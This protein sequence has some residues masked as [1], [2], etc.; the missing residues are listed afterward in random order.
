MLYGGQL[1]RDAAGQLRLGGTGYARAGDN[2]AETATARG[3]L[4]DLRNVPLV[5]PLRVRGCG[6]HQ[7]RVAACAATLGFGMEPLCGSLEG[8]VLVNLLSCGG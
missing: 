1:Y 6:A 7:P 2:V 3:Q 8:T 4:R 5:A